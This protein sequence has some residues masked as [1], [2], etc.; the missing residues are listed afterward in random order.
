MN[1]DRCDA[2]AVISSMWSCNVRSRESV[3]PCRRV[4]FI[5]SISLSF[6]VIGGTILLVVVHC[7]TSSAVARSELSTLE[8]EHDSHNCA[9]ISV[10]DVITSCY[11]VIYMMHKTNGTKQFLCG[12]AVLIVVYIDIILPGFIRC[13]R[14]H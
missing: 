14:W 12:T 3:T 4:H 10:F 8:G 13:L 11:L 6:T 1:Y 9:V 5:F 2:L 7:V